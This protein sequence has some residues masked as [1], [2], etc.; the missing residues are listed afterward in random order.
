MED[1]QVCLKSKLHPILEDIFLFRI[2]CNSRI[3]EVVLIPVGRHGPTHDCLM[4]VVC[5]LCIASASLKVAT[6][7]IEWFEF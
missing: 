7:E 3:E 4:C 5:K 6:E 2:L 1:F